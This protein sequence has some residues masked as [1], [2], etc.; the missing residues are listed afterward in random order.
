MYAACA[1][2]VFCAIHMSG[3]QHAARVI[4]FRPA[5]GQFANL[6]IGMHP[7]AALGAPDTQTDLTDT[8]VISLGA[9]GGYIILGFDT[10]VKNDPRNPYGV[11]FTIN[12]NTIDDSAGSAGCE[13]AAV[14]VM[15]D[16]NG[17][18]IPDDGPWLELAGSDYWFP[19]ARRNYTMTY[20]NPLYTNAHAVGWTGSDSETGALLTVGAHTQPYYPDPFLYPG[21][22]LTNTAFTGTRIAGSADRR[23]PNSVFS[24]RPPAFGYADSHRNNPSPEHPL[25]PYY[26]DTKGPV[27]DGFD[28][29]WAVDQEGNSVELDQIDFIR[30]YTASAAGLGWLGES[31]SE[32]DA[33]TVTEPDP[34]C[35][36]QDYYLHYICVRQTSVALGSTASFPAMLFKNG[37]P[38]AEGTPAYTVSNPAVGTISPDG[39]FT[40]L[41]EGTTAISFSAL[42]GVPADEVEVT[43]TSIDG[44]LCTLGS[45]PSATAKA[46]CIAGE[47]LWL[48]MESTDN[49]AAVTGTSAGNRYIHD[50]YIWRTTNPAVGDID[51]HGTF[52]ATAAGTTIVSA[53]SK[54]NPA[55]YAEVQITVK[56]VPAIAPNRTSLDI[57]SDSPQ[58][59]WTT[60]TLLRSTNRSTVEITEAS[61]RQG[62]IPVTLVANRVCYDC[63][64]ISAEYGE[65]TVHDTLDLTVRH[66]GRTLSFSIPM[67]YTPARSGTCAAIAEPDETDGQYFTTGGIQVSGTP[68]VPG[69]YLYRTSGG[70]TIKTVVR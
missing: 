44:V 49:Y 1:A 2:A 52:T 54:A 31:S 24:H 55:C 56:D 9:F 35:T 30:I 39:L 10:P 22:E 7:E 57:P 37:K 41:S 68:A 60:A 66:Y 17:N 13:P 20:T 64:G 63:T 45:R 12:G 16:L 29:S 53:T 42:T 59:N 65:D 34:D 18:G 21:T 5:P 8:G 4:E 62:Q 27:A 70:K 69:I 46:D 32:I 50:S 14:A 3:A 67:S 11:D 48:P 61:S 26:A 28:I 19:S 23:N 36:P 33:V 43:V 38:C 6:D 25:N 40:P 47:T 58:G 15:K 51:S